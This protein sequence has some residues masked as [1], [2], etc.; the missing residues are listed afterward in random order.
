MVVG[1][2]CAFNTLCFYYPERL[3]GGL[4]GLRFGLQIVTIWGVGGASVGRASKVTIWTLDRDHLGGWASKVTI[5][6]SWGNKWVTVTFTGYG[7]DLG[8]KP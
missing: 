1:I 6:P 8:G 2:L 3:W 4:Q 5:W 7:Y